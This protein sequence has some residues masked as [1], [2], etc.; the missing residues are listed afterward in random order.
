[1]GFITFIDHFK[2][3]WAI[4]KILFCKSSK[5]HRLFVEY[6]IKFVFC[7]NSI[8]IHLLIYDIKYIIKNIL[9]YL[10]KK[11]ISALHCT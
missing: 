8:I 11:G 1:M 6:G 2:V 10:G 7:N 5:I 9:Y 3:T 4:V